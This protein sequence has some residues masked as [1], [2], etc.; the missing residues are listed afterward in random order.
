[1]KPAPAP[2]LDLDSLSAMLLFLVHSEDAV[3]RAVDGC[4]DFHEPS[5]PEARVLA[6]LLEH[7]SK[8]VGDTQT[9]LTDVELDM[10]AIRESKITLH[11]GVLEMDFYAPNLSWFSVYDLFDAICQ[12]ETVKARGGE[13]DMRHAFFEGV[14]CSSSGHYEVGWGS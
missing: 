4:A 3:L 5:K 13:T 10:V 12:I 6:V 1:M 2:S 8:Q 14:H 7:P 9:P 11:A